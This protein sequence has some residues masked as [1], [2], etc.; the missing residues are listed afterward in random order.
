MT[1]FLIKKFIKNNENLSDPTVRSSYAT[2]SSITGIVVNFFLFL[3]KLIVGLF[4]ASVAIIADAFN[5]ISDAGSAIVTLIGFRLSSKHVD[6][7]HPLGHGRMEYVTGFIVD[8]L[9]LLVGFE[10]L[11]GSIEK[12]FKPTL[13]HV[14]TLTYVI[15]GCAILVKLWLFFFYRKIG[16]T[17]NSSA[18][19]AAATDS[20]SDCGATAL[21]LISAILS[22][23]F[24]ISVDGIAGLVVAGLI[25]FAGDKAAKETIDLLLGSPPTPEFIERIYAFVKNY[26]EIVGIHDVMV[27]DYGPGRQIMSFHAEIPSDYDV[28]L[29]HEIIDQIERDMHE[30]FNAI[31]TI[32]LDPIAVNDEEVNGMRAFAI[33]CIKEIDERFSLH[34]FRMTKGDKHVNL[35]FDLVIPVDCKTD[36]FAAAQ[37]VADKIKERNENCFAVIKP[38]HPFV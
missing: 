11:T 18:I 27:H 23:T 1:N 5:N 9:I 12:I 32:H 28:N 21:V 16:K 2:L 4:S 14:S 36:D 22:T 7:E 25:L 20:I 31:V 29:A 37:A 3:G 26:P 38:E 33:E 15:L 24:Q 8:M 6:K 19:T 30:E 17:I 10:L 13:P 35:I 34:D